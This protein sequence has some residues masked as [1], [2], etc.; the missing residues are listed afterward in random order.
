MGGAKLVGG[1]I[2]HLYFD[3]ERWV[4][5]RS[6]VI[7]VWGDGSIP[8]FTGPSKGFDGRVLYSLTGKMKLLS[9][10]HE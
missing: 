8:G 3:C 10:K 6:I 9:L 7:H 4:S 1:E 5:S 2:N